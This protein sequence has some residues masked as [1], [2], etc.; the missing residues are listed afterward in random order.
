MHEPEDEN[1]L[2]GQV[3]T[4]CPEEARRPELHV[5]QKSGEPVHVPQLEEQAVQV[6]LSCGETKVPVGQLATHFPCKRKNPGR[7]PVH[8][9]WLIVDPALKFV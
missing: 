7:Q 2:D 1:E 3:E 6:R 8:C 5:R 9:S 4:H